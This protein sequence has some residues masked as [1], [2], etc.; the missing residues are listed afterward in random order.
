[1]EHHFTGG[2]SYQR[3]NGNEFSI[4]VMYSPENSISGG[5]FFDPSQQIELTMHQFEIEV[6][7]RF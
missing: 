7:Y 3:Q 2:F 5:N 4:A 6:S 1:M